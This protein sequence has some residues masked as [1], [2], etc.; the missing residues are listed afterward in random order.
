MTFV[1]LLWASLIAYSRIYL[2]VHY[3]ADVLGGAMLGSLVG[4]VVYRVFDWA[5]KHWAEWVAKDQSITIT[6]S[7]SST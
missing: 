2:G 6:S 5:M 1:L 4:F 3:P 7:N